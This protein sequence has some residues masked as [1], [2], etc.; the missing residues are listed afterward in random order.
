MKTIELTDEQI[1]SAFE[2]YN[3]GSGIKTTE[4]RRKL[5]AQSLFKA[6]SGYSNGRTV[7]QI[8]IY[9]GLMEPNQRMLMPTPAQPAMRWAYHQY[10]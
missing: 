5:L 3:F 2:G 7:G 6:A 10:H 9:L 4:D 1:D 8:L